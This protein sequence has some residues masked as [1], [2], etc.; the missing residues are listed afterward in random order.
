MLRVVL[1]RTVGDLRLPAA[2][3]VVAAANPPDEAADGWELAPP[4]ANRLVHLD[5]PTDGRYIARGL[6]VGFPAPSL[7]PVRRRP[8]RRDRSA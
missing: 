4:L 3:R 5:W 6:A 2:V 1:E 7:L 8:A